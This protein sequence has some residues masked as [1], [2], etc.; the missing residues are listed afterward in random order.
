MCP[1]LCLQFS[2]FGIANYNPHAGE[3]E[4]PDEEDTGPSFA[5]SNF[6]PKTAQSSPNKNVNDKSP[7]MAS[8]DSGKEK[9]KHSS[10]GSDSR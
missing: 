5:L 1:F 7:K 4:P 8:S 6:A 3:A 10:S 2:I 9:D